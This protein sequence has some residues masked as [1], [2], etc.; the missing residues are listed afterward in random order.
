MRKS[1]K[2]TLTVLLASTMVFGLASCANSSSSSTSGT[3]SSTSSAATDEKV[4]LKVWHQWADDS[5]ALKSDYEKAVKAYEDANP[6]I[7][8]ESDALA[9]EAYKTKLTTAFA[10]NSA[11]CDV[12]YDWSPGK[13]AS[14]AQAGRLLAI[15]DYVK[16]GTLDQIQPGSTDA[17]TFD[18]KLYSLPMFS[19]YMILFCNRDL[20]DQ[21]G[22]TE[23]TTLDELIEA[24]EKLSAKGIL[25]IT[26]G[27]KDAWNACFIYEF[28]AMRQNGASNVNKYLSG[29]VKMDDGYATAAE[30][31][32][33]LVKANVFGDSTLA[34]GNVDAD[35]AFTTGKAAMRIAGS[36]DASAC[37]ADGS[38]VK[39]KVDAKLLPLVPD[40]KGGETNFCG[41]FTESFLVNAD[42]KY[43]EQAVDFMKY[44]NKTMGKYAAE[45]SS[46]FDAWTDETI[47][48]SG[49]NDVFKQ[50]NEMT[51]NCEASTLAWDTYLDPAKT[52]VH[53]DDVMALFGDKMTPEDFVKNENASWD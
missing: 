53:Q 28:L 26:N 15:D 50:I 47:D 42:T 49:W 24:S 10:G 35:T 36:W 19:W 41:G 17:F 11:D 43:P 39:D 40:G 21:A 5:N 52:K 48:E 9:T 33:K 44:I 51:K 27:T 18:G 38:T 7:T 12:F 20:F 29:E 1:L 37:Y 25:P 45:T 6:N 13:T 22:A 8:I 30:N 34:T 23:P 46:G 31:L 14:L 32:Q 2:R 16:D 4:T 3:S